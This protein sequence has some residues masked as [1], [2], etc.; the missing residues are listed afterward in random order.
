MMSAVFWGNEI[1]G[2]I[3]TGTADAAAAGVPGDRD[4][5][6]TGGVAVGW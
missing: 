3:R 5:D 1:S 6:G 2:P 4:G